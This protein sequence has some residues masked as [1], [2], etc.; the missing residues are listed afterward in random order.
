[1]AVIMGITEVVSRTLN[2][3]TPDPTKKEGAVD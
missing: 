3:T 1:M 2:P